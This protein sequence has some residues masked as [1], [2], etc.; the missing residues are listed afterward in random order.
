M[1]FFYD[2]KDSQDLLRKCEYDYE[3]LSKIGRNQPVYS[4]VLFN[5]ILGLNHI[6]DWV[7]NDDKNTIERKVSCITQFNPYRKDEHLPR[8]YGDLYETDGLILQTNK[9]QRMVRL[10][11]NRVKHL[12][13][14][15]AKTE[16]AENIFSVGIKLD[17]AWFTATIDGEWM[18]VTAQCAFLLDQWRQFH[19]QVPK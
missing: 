16:K 7:L 4:F 9:Q 11:A 10:L 8:E 5:L 1:T 19:G 6:F 2:I 15:K 14:E 13:E 18:E 17:T 3:Q 12:N